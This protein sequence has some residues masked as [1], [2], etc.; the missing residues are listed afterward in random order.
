MGK[1]NFHVSLVLLR[2]LSQALLLLLFFFLFI[3]TDYSGSD[4]LAYAVNILFRI[5][6]FL[7][8]SVMLAAKTVVALMLPALAVVLLTL[9]LGRFFCGW[10]CPLGTLIDLSHPLFRSG[11]R[12]FATIFPR[13]PYFILFFA[14]AAAFFGLPVAGYFD[15][16]SILVRGL[17][18][19][20]YPAFDHTA[21]ALFSWTYREAPGFV[22]AVTE[23]FYAGLRSTVLPFAH[24]YFT[25]SVLSASILAAVFLLEFFQRRFFCRNICPLGA[26]NGLTARI[27]LLNGQG[28]GNDCKKCRNCRTVCRMEAIDEDR[29]IAMEKCILCMDCLEKCPKNTIAFRYGGASTETPSF[30]L[31]R[32][33]LVASL[34]GGALLPLLASARSI[35][36]IPDPG[37]IRPP[38]A[39]PEKDFLGR[40][41]RCGECMQVCIGNALHPAFL[42][43]GFEGMFSPVL[44]AR[45]GYCEFN[46]TLCGQ[47]CPTGAI[48]ELELPAK[49]TLKIGHAW[50]DRDR[51]LPHAKG[52]PCIVCEEHCPTP[53]KAIQ[54]REAE[55]INDAGE[56]V[57][58]RQPYV[59]DRLCI[60]CGICEHKCPLPGRAAVYITA[61]GEARHPQSSLPSSAPG[62]FQDLGNNT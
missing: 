8:A 45:I 24:R 6:P 2:R 4:Q 41:I 1:R 32:R 16:F 29:R 21:T 46:C 51:C 49:H 23:P 54:F 42:E 30:S 11:K 55:V 7:A 48:R 22:N 37:L 9:L 10:V 58:V 50:F 17:A 35:A 56:K 62:Y 61:D 57:R 47:V 60:G 20:V 3:K 39:L 5:D 28:G 33:V 14:L 25:L 38:G 43:A 15:P 53:E 31:P 12:I 18:L 44:Q 13:L 27:G 40:C 52:I 59:V 34:A 36:R 26:L 19:A